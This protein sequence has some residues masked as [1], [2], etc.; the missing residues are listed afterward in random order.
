MNDGVINHPAGRHLKVALTGDVALELMA[1]YFQK[2]GYEVYVPA[3]FGT[4]RQEL[5]DPA[6][7]LNRFKPD[8]I[9]DV[10]GADAALSSEV[11]G[12]YDERMRT[13][14]SM[15]Y[16]LDG[17]AAIVEEL[18]YRALSAPKKIL[19]VDADETLWRGIL[20]EDGESAL[21][22]MDVLQEGILKLRRDGVLPVL[23][24][25]NDPF[26]FRA[27][28]PLAL[29]DFVAV[30]AG[31]RSKTENL[32]EA[33]AELDLGLDSVVFL[34]DNP[35]ERA[36][37]S[38]RLAEVTVVP[39]NG[40][41]TG[42]EIEQ[43]QLVR[44]LCECFFS[45]AGATEEDRL[46]AADYGRRAQARR[47]I[48]N[49]ASVGDY[50]KSLDL[51]VEASPAKEGD[52]DRLAQMA[53]KTNQFNATV[54][55]RTRDEFA[56]LLS[57]PGRRVFVFRTSDRFGEQGLVCYIIADLGSRAITDFVM[58]CRVM[59][60]TLEHF[61]YSHV[62]EELGFRPQI[63]FVPTAK[64][65]PFAGFLSSLDDGTTTWYEKTKETRK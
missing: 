65:G 30:K 5:L 27:D 49:F 2:A 32:A 24:S 13:L 25:K 63:E 1:P 60:R 31:W 7:G 4:W 3:G 64:N 37:M 61:A 38:A 56:S 10:T 35:R 44:R 45:G 6:S 20:S 28:M 40:W 39:W 34:D 51:R 48:A 17:I 43:R 11:C 12:F 52:L 58:S 9:Y 50:L 54:R 21:E 14:A 41:R 18:G 47:E 19:A 22:A 59:G 36:E 42:D 26:D 23:L 15:P 46:R 8:F 62:S 53:A 57:D 29:S 16:S 33:C 55:R